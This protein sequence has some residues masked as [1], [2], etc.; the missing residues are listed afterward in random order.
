MELPFFHLMTRVQLRQWVEA[1]PERVNDRDGHDSTPLYA[2]ARQL[3]SLPL[4]AWLLDEK[5]AD[6][7]ARA[8][9]GNTPLHAAATLDILIALLDR[10]ADPTVLT[11]HGWTP[12]MSQAF[13]GR[14]DCMARLLQDSRVRATINVQNNNGDTALHIACDSDDGTSTTSIVHLLLQAGANPAV[15]NNDGETPLA[16]RRHHYTSR[17]AAI[18]LLEQAPDAET[19]SLLVKARRL[20]TVSRNTVAPFYLQ[21]RVVDGLPLPRVALAPMAAGSDENEEEEEEEGRTFRSMLAFVFGMEGGPENMGMPRDVLR[22]VVD[23][24]MPTWDPLR[25]KHDDAGQQLQG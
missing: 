18:A 10:G 1:N 25:R 14:V 22:V 4:V 6:I 20:V 3:K 11:N 9:Y 21:R 17:N 5:G 15:T 12:L 7:N 8:W 16:V 19:T 24:L 23:L 2:A 13:D